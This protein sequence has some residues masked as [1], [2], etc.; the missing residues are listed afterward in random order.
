MLSGCVVAS[1]INAA[2][3]AD[4]HELCVEDCELQYDHDPVEFDL[5]LDDCEWDY[6]DCK[7]RVEPLDC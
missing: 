6:E 3:C 4:D 5:C 1:L 2:V 7:S